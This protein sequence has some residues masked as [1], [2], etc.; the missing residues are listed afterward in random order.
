MV[1]E[2]GIR[3]ARV[4]MVGIDVTDDQALD[5][6]LI[7]IQELKKKALEN[8]VIVGVGNKID[9]IEERKISTEEA[10]KFFE[11]QG[12][13][14]YFETSARTGEGVTEAF[15]GAVRYWFGSVPDAFK[16]LCR[17]NSPTYAFQKKAEEKCMIQ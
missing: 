8:V 2:M 6:C 16:V 4:I 14:R 11:E 17:I 7:F 3:R 15:E 10:R 12:V 13:M 1:M 9:R 5:R